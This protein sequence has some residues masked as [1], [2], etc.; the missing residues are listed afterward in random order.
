M[1]NL[2]PS[3][4]F[5]YLLISILV[6]FFFF[7]NKKNKILKEKLNNVQKNYLDLNNEYKNLYLNHKNLKLEKNKNLEV[8]TD[9][10]N[11]LY[12]FAEF[13]KLSAGVFH[14]IINPLTAISLNLEH[15]Q[16]GKSKFNKCFLNDAIYST[17]KMQSFVISVK[18]QINNQEV[19]K[20]FNINEEIED[21]ICL[22][23]YKAKKNK[24]RLIFKHSKKIYI[25]GLNIKFNQVILNLISNAIDSYKNIKRDNNRLVIIKI[26]KDKTKLKITVQDFGEGIKKEE[27]NKIFKAFYSTKKTLTNSTQ[28]D[29]NNGIGLHNSMY[30][31]NKYFKGNLIVDSKYGKGT[32]MILFLNTKNKNNT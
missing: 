3:S 21:C 24:V 8:Y 23:K 14:D 2:E 5:N 25:L 31:L 11:D 13:G 27:Q 18:K 9:K 7:F 6:I 12:R 4:F 29:Q 30:I 22:L 15:L 32:K 19:E 26:T 1:L 20:Y 10:I 17:K 28:K 16:Q